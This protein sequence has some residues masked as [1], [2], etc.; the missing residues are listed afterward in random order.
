[1]HPELS[2]A[3]PGRDVSNILP[4]FFL[5]VG[6]YRWYNGAITATGQLGWM[7]TMLQTRGCC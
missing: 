3:E 1:M 2:K 6:T 5:D 4:L 7:M